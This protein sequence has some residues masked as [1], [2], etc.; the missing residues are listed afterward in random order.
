MR[1]RT[2][3][4]GALGSHLPAL[5]ERRTALRKC[6]QKL[7]ELQAVYMPG[8]VPLLAQLPEAQ[9]DTEYMENVRLGLP[10]DISST[11][12]IAVCSNDLITLESRL[13]EAQ[14]RDSLQD[15]RNKI[16][17]L[18]HLYRFKKRNVRHQGPN[19]RAW[20]ELDQ[21]A[22]KR[23]RAVEK[24]RRARRAKLALDGPGEWETILRDLRDEDVRG[25]TPIDD[26]VNSKPSR[27][28]KRITTGTGPGEGHQKISWIWNASDTLGSSSHVESLRI[29]WLKAHARSMRWQ[30]ETK[31]LP[32]EMRRTL[33]AMQGEEQAWVHRAAPREGV[34]ERLQEGLTAYAVDQ[35][36]VRRDMRT[37][38]QT[39]C[40]GIMKEAKGELGPEWSHVASSIPVNPEEYR[41]P[42]EA[43]SGWEGYED[44]E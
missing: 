34:D 37:T 27:K 9:T 31:L 38:F 15:V 30:E 20:S 24:Y 11:H 17:T 39:I 40:S 7:R 1:V 22:L 19:M 5:F 43:A 2:D 41:A 6:I 33:E 36:Q 13:R 32:E 16:H 10:S 3:A 35:A 26:E 18:H 4:K 44:L 21:H 42:D 14:C 29:E 28:R 25:V 8:A 12:R 23:D